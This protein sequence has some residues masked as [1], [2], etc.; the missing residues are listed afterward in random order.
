M[1]RTEGMAQKDPPDVAKRCLCLE[2]LL[3]RLGLEIDDDDPVEERET[4]RV[5]WLSRVGDL[6]LEELLLPEER[7]FLERP[8]GELTEEETDDIEGRVICAL[9]L[10]WAMRRLGAR[11]SAAMLGDATRL[12]SEYGVLGDGSIST[13]NATARSTTLR[14][15]SELREELATYTRTQGDGRGEGE[16]QEEQMVSMLAVQ[17]LSW[18]LG[19]T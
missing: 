6:A 5:A 18:M 19:A 12:I 13:A 14:P 3:Q 10:L 9:V 4:V 1:V 15:E 7:A 17:T 8:V 2:L 16:G 11:P